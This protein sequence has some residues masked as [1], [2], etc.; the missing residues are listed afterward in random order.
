[1]FIIDGLLGLG[2]IFLVIAYGLIV[3]ALSTHRIDAT[4]VGLVKKRAAHKKL[5]DDDPIAFHG[6][7]G[8]QAELLMPGLRFKIWPLYSVTKHPWVQVGAGDIG[9]VISQVGHP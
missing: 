9:V 2:L 4:E 8:Y 6:E 5:S 1:M 3:V 7:S